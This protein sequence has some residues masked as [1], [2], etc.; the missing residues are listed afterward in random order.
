MLVYRVETTEGFGPY[1]AGSEFRSLH[2]SSL[3]DS[4]NEHLLKRA[5]QLE[6]IYDSLHYTQ[7]SEDHPSVRSDVRNFDRSYHCCCV[8]LELLYEWFEPAKEAL[9]D[10]GL[11]IAVY[12]VEDTHVEHGSRQSI[13]NRSKATFVESRPL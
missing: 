6:D 4:G 1:N 2:G 7:G 11:F 13:F 12:D 8:T 9:K 5:K 10:A 3:Y